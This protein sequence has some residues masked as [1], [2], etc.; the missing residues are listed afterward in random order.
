MPD[1]VS[2][3]RAIISETSRD[4]SFLRYLS[5]TGQ[6]FLTAG[7][8]VLSSWGLKYLINRIGAGSEFYLLQTVADY[9]SF[10]FFMIF[11]LFALL[12][13]SI[14]AWGNLKYHWKQLK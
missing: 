5:I 14:D 13:L 11:A 1:E 12:S 6:G 3:S 4:I 2:T 7:A 9:V 10:I 8:T